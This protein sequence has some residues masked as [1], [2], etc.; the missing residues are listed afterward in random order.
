MSHHLR[1]YT[2]KQFKYV[3]LTIMGLEVA[4]FLVFLFGTLGAVL[5]TYSGISTTD[6]ILLG[7]GGIVVAFLMLTGAEMLQLLMKIEFGVRKTDSLVAQEIELI[8]SEE[9]KGTR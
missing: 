3:S 1:H 2:K 6:F 4:A 8:K 9:R 5:G 7:F